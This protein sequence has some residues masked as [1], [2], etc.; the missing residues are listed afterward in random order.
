MHAE[1][2]QLGV[3]TSAKPQARHSPGGTQK[4]D[5]NNLCTKAEA[6]TDVT[7]FQRKEKDEVR[8]SKNA[9][10][11]VCTA[12]IRLTVLQVNR[13]QKGVLISK[14]PQATLQLDPAF[15]I[16]IISKKQWKKKLGNADS[17]NTDCPD[18]V[19]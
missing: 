17:Y 11:T 5:E 14:G 12:P 2:A 13:P 7:Q 16:I 19:G 1:I 10:L 4:I 8:W 9:L 15:D 6:S 18:C 3:L